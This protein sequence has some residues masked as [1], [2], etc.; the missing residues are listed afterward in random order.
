M[1]RDGGAH[2]FPGHTCEAGES[3]GGEPELEAI[4][5]E[6]RRHSSLAPLIT[7]LLICLIFG[8]AFMGRRGTYLQF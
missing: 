6:W 1:T 4:R 8:E 5:A 7:K 2:R 3:I